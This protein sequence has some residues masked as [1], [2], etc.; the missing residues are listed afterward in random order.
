MKSLSVVFGTTLSCLPF[1]PCL[2][3]AAPDMS[4]AWQTVPGPANSA[5]AQ[6]EGVACVSAADCWVVGGAGVEGA[7][8]LAEHWNGQSWL[9]VATPQA[10]SDRSASYLFGVACPTA[11]QCIAVGANITENTP[12]A[13]VTQSG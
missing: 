6:V 7:P 3:W 8:A 12:L 2:G 4:S 1:A 5:G 11:T 9:Y 13:E 10:P